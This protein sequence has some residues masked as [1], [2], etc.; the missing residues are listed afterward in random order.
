M[1]APKILLKHAALGATIVVLALAT[2]YV[3]AARGPTEGTEL[4]LL[5]RAAIGPREGAWGSRPLEGP[6]PALLVG[7]ALAHG[8]LG[9]LRACSVVVMASGVAATYVATRTL[10][11]AHAARISALVLA[12]LPL[13]AMHAGTLLPDALV[14]AAGA[15]AFACVALVVRGEAAWRAR[16][17]LVG[18]ALVSLAVGAAV[19]GLL[20]GVLVPLSPVVALLVDGAPDRR[21]KW[22]FAC[23]GGALVAIVIL[24]LRAAPSFASSATT[25]DAPLASAVHELFPWSIALPLAWSALVRGARTTDGVRAFCTSVLCGLAVAYAVHLVAARAGAKVPFVAPYLVA[26]AI[27]LA[28]READRASVAASGGP[29]AVALLAALVFAGLLGRDAVLYPETALVPFSYAKLPLGVVARLSVV[30]PLVAA[31]FVVGLVVVAAPR[32]P[33]VRLV[34]RGT[35]LVGWGTA[36]AL[37][38]VVLHHKVVEETLSPTPAF[39][40]YRARRDTR[41]R[42]ALLG[43]SETL[44][45][46][47]A[48]PYAAVHDD[49][50]EAGRWLDD[51]P[52][53]YLVAARAE[54]AGVNS[55]YRARFGRNVPELPTSPHAEA[56][57]FVGALSPSERSRNPLDE[58]VFSRDPSGFLPV[59]ATFSLPVDAI[60]IRVVNGKGEQVDSVAPGFVGRIDV[61]YR[62]RGEGVDG[63]CSFVHVDVRPTRAATEVRTFDYPMRFWHA[64]DRVV[65]S[66]ELAIPRGAAKGRAEVWFGL[67]VLPCT[68]DRR[69]SVVAARTSQDRAYGG[70]ID[71]R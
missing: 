66:H 40:T 25:W 11:D 27:G 67:G 21:K 53:R 61:V 15:I 7:G 63:H 5:V 16:I 37:L 13:Y 33:L 19:R 56:T 60:G 34:P 22:L 59:S 44:A 30:V 50:T 31:A 32:L 65:V 51:D 12:T 48:T 57:L 20:V 3:L 36:G 71:V 35:W 9:L 62:A 18:V 24:A 52:T 17:V 70:S 38:F 47:S 6:L 49:A 64:G 41:T 45:K 2:A 68:D 10:V 55:V 39:D 58:T 46:V 4:R 43:V 26:M 42:L 23:L 29:S 54:R 1:T 69:A 14:F 8:M 28:A